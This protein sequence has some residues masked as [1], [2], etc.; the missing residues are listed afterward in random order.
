MFVYSQIFTHYRNYTI[1]SKTSSDILQ[2]TTLCLQ[3]KNMTEL[4]LKQK[5]E[6][7]KLLFLK[8]TLNQKEIAAKV[9]VT[10]KT[11][12]SWVNDSKDNWEMLR[13]SYIITREQ[14]LRRIY[15]QISEMNN[16]IASRPDGERFA[17]SKE[18]DALA[19]LAVAAK[20]LEAETSIS[21]TISV[22][23]EFIEW[24]KEVDYTKAKEFI[25]Y[26]DGFI[27]HKLSH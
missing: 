18:A 13:S 5:K 17:N 20:S 16:A 21:E 8:S 2:L 12:S 1:Y 22:F 3:E 26:Q 7:A 24:L 19:K 27:K 6:W 25:G 10:E 15:V 23:R 4:P 11:M 14:E 9:G